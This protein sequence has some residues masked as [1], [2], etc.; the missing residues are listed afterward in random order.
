MGGGGQSGTVD[1]PVHIKNQH[2]AF[3]GMSGD[4]ALA[5]NQSLRDV[6]NTALSL[7]N[8]SGNAQVVFNIL[9]FSVYTEERFIVSIGGV[10]SAEVSVFSGDTQSSLATKLR[11]AINS[12]ALNVNWIATASS[13]TVT[14]T[15]LAAGTAWNN[16]PVIK[17]ITLADTVGGGAGTYWLVD[18]QSVNIGTSENLTLTVDGDSVVFDV[19]EIV[20]PTSQTAMKDLMIAKLNADATVGTR[21]TASSYSAYIMKLTYNTVGATYNGLVLS[22]SLPLVNGINELTLNYLS[23]SIGGVDP[24]VGGSNISFSSV[25]SGGG[26]SQPGGNPFADLSFTDPSADITAINN[27]LTNYGAFVATLDPGTDWDDLLTAAISGSLETNALL[28]TALSSVFST[29]IT[30]AASAIADS[31]SKSV[32]AVDVAGVLQTIDWSAILEQIVTDDLAGGLTNN[33]V[34]AV[35]ASGVLSTI[36]VDALLATALTE[37]DTA[38][39]ASLASVIASID[40]HKIEDAVQAFAIRQNKVKQK[41]VRQFTSTMS[42]I[43]AVQSSAFMFGL[44]IIEAEYL[45]NVSDFSTTTRL[46]L[47]KEML[48]HYFTTYRQLVTEYMRARLQEKISR[49]ALIQLIFTQTSSYA[50]LAIQAEI[51][52]KTSREQLIAL[53]AQAYSN[54]YAQSVASLT[55]GATLDKNNRDVF[56]QNAIRN[57]VELLTLQLQAE[58]TLVGETRLAKQVGIAARGDYVS[59]EIVLNEKFGLWDLEVFNFGANMLGAAGGGTYVPKAPPAWQQTVATIAGA[60]GVIGGLAK[61][62]K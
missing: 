56:M 60:V 19:S 35:D 37:L 30:N 34:A 50:P 15:A 52:N 43:N 22:D 10:D 47:Y 16:L 3:L 33:A 26:I 29:A 36:D 42:A 9:A 44:A 48:G 11:N 57:M 32:A 62:G 18:I 59:N 49:E 23:G 2:K 41:S 6:M 38:M 4:S 46:E 21:F 53:M 13:S 27:A 25:T 40:L 12:S 14:V 17:T 20:S 1:F 28:P 39:Q 24:G 8:F 54:S 31:M 55:E 61:P 45:Q 58:Q 7:G 51:Q 5:L